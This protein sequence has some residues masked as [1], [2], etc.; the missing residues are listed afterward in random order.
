MSSYEFY[1]NDYGPITADVLAADEE[2]PITPISATATIVNQHTGE[3]VV[4]NAGALTD[5]G[6][7]TYVIPDGSPITATPARYVAYLTAVIDAT[8]KRTVAIPIDVLDKGSHFAV[9]RWR[10]KVEFS[11]PDDDALSDQ[12]GRDWI[13]QAVA[14]INKHYYDTGYTSTLASLAPADGVDPAGP[15]EIEFFASVAAL[16]A[17]TAW[18]AGKGNWRDEEMSLDTGPFRDEW[19]ALRESLAATG[20]AEWFKFDGPYD[21]W[22]MYNRDKV[23]RFGIADA[24]D[25]YYESS[26]A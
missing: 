12:E 14:H 18:W 6:L 24:P 11:A 16:M 1:V 9:D 26:W 23:D 25:N 17:R 15:N 7:M 20:T 10:R 13:D 3:V 21:Q 19:A 2:T 5:E 4:E 8:T 22:S